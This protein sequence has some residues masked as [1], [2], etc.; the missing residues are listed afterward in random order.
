ME[1]AKVIKYWTYESESKYAGDS[2]A[3]I[4]LQLFFFFIPH[5][6]NIAASC[7]ITEVD[8][9]Q[10]SRTTVASFYL[11]S[12]CQLIIIPKQVLKPGSAQEPHNL[13]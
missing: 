12:Q 3:W 6:H 7:I 13:S 4:H 8:C 1:Y 2:K 9:W 10:I 5:G 11:V